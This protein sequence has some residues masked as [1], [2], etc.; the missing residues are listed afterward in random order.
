MLSGFICQS[1][2]LASFSAGPQFTKTPP[3]KFATGPQKPSR[4]RPSHVKRPA[5]PNQI[6]AIEERSSQLVSQL[7]RSRFDATAAARSKRPSKM[8]LPSV[9]SDQPSLR[10]RHRNTKGQS[11]RR[12]A[13]SALSKISEVPTDASRWIDSYAKSTELRPILTALRSNEDR[14]P[15]VLSDEGLLY[16]YIDDPDGQDMEVPRLV[17]PEGVIRKELMETAA[18][19]GGLEALSRKYW[20]ESMQADYWSFVNHCDVFR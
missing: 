18:Y 19:E 7:R 14:D 6:A 15:F 17:P 12:S 5:R 1:E 4:R 9:Y 3:P 20:W 10:S 13:V 11:M 2:S 8:S 16:I